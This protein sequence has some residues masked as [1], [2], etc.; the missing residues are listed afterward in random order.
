VFQTEIRVVADVLG[1]EQHPDDNLG[2]LNNSS[3]T[4]IGKDSL[5]GQHTNEFHP[6]YEHGNP[7]SEEPFSSALQYYHHSPFNLT[8][9]FQPRISASQ[10][11]P[12]YGPPWQGYNLDED[13]Y[14]GSQMF[15]PSNISEQ[16]LSSPCAPP[17]PTGPRGNN[18]VI[19]LISCSSTT[20]EHESGPLR[21]PPF[22]ITMKR[23]QLA[24]KLQDTDILGITDLTL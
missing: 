8:A 21:R 16:G 22:S 3:Q 14:V 20:P 1:S 5:F 11:F 15:A 23:F 9:G 7:H 19:Q 13:G 12:S 6:P 4:V 17:V 18:P 24:A 10:G 2:L